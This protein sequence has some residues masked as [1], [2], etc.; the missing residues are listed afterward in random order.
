MTIAKVAGKRIRLVHVDGPVGV[1]S[2]NFTN[3]RIKSLG[4]EPQHTLEQGIAKTYPWIAE[5][6][7]RQVVYA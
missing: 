1:Q 6:L 4:W 2:R 5:Q 3:G 7:K